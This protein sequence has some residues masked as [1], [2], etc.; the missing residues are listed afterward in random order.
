M[1]IKYLKF[2]VLIFILFSSVSSFAENSQ[3]KTEILTIYQVMQRVLDHHP[4]LKIAELDIAQAAQQRRQ[5][6]SSLGWILNSSLGVTHDL[7]PIGRPSDRLDINGSINRQLES[8]ATLTLN[9]GYRYED[10]SLTFSPLLP[11]PA[12]TTRLDLSYR[13]PLAQGNGNPLYTEGLISA[14]ANHELAKENFSLM[15]I[16]LADKVK[17]LFYNSV[18]VRKKIINAQQ[19]VLRTKKLLKYIKKN[20][21]LGLSENKDQLQINA[22]LYSKTAELSA[23]QI[24][25]Q[26]LSYSLSRLILQR[27]PNYIQPVLLNDLDVNYYNLNELLALTKDS[28]PAIEVSRIQLSIAQ[29]KINSAKD[30]KKDNLDLVMSVGT[31]TLSGNNI[32]GTVNDNNWA[33]AVSIEYKHLFDNDGTSSKYQQALLEKN[34]ALENLKK[35]NDDIFYSVSGLVAEITSAKKSVKETKRRLNGELLKLQE[36]EVRFRNGRVD[37][38][39][40]IQFQNEYSFA[41]LSYQIQKVEL[42]KRIIA[43][44]IYSGKFWNKLFENKGSL[45]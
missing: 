4:S 40:L 23:L 25:W 24:Q 32:S 34:I 35:T 21:K 41:E 27:K 30:E 9:G 37:T 2:T 33:G 6:E 20:L 26:Q 44:Q 31:R 8:G 38:A 22:Q 39:K 12:Y 7:S 5:I 43:L 18:L 1:N 36:A 10:S 45:R 28:H 15:R 16:S 17:D 14:D 42:N 13:L 19:S 29:S 3:H 11:N